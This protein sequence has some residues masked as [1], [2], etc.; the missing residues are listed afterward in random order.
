MQIVST[1]F[2]QTSPAMDVLTS[3]A[4]RFVLLLI[5]LV[6]LYIALH[7]PGHG[8]AET[9]AIICLATL[10]GV[11]L[12]AGI[13]P[14]WTI[15][16]VVVGL[17]LIAMEVFVLPGFGLPGLAG[18][19][20]FLGGLIFL[21][22]SPNPSAM[23]W[24]SLRNALL[25]VTS[26]L[27]CAAAACIIL[28]RHLPRIPYLRQIILQRPDDSAPVASEQDIWPF[29]GAIGTAVTDLRPGGSAE[30]PFGHELRKTHVVCDGRFVPAGSKVV[31]HEISGNRVLVRVMDQT[32]G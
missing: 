3:P 25:L 8:L 22:A 31:V 2:A 30:F 21:F 6:S 28:R 23:D 32:K 11:P 7:V 19:I 26:S 27:I 29:L 17:V 14:W 18:L 24:Q 20:L 13:A 12:V 4:L 9:V 15:A 10:L 1:I 5:F 16:A